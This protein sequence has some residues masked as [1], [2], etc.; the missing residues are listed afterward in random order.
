MLVHIHIHT[1][2]HTYTH[3]YTHTHTYTHIHPSPRSSPLILPQDLS[4]GHWH[5]YRC[6]GHRC[7]Y[8]LTTPAK[9]PGG[10]AIII[11]AIATKGTVKVLVGTAIKQN[12]IKQ[13]TL[14]AAGHSDEIYELRVTS[15][16]QINITIDFIDPYSAC[17]L[18]YTFGGCDAAR[19]NLTHEGIV[20]VYI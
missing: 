9:I 17:E 4:R 20:Y 10:Q 19:A 14:D 5:A 8:V 2:T 7:L 1:Y 3:I 18:K 11:H 16:S 15:A 6:S 12:K 13:M